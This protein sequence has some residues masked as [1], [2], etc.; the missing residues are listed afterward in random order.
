[1]TDRKAKLSARCEARAT[2]HI[3]VLRSFAGGQENNC[4]ALVHTLAQVQCRHGQHT[5]THAIEQ[6][7]TMLTRTSTRN[8]CHD[9]CFADGRPDTVELH[10]CN[11]KGFGRARR[12]KTTR[13]LWRLPLS[14]RGR[15]SLNA[16]WRLLKKNRL[17]LERVHQMHRQPNQNQMSQRRVLEK[18]H[19]QL[20]ARPV[21]Q[22]RL[23]T[24]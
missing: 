8:I 6:W 15:R 14:F 21:L 13:G 18:H 5:H 10:P 20:L 17:K 11:S 22:P 24:N 23:G 12:S 2:C 3:N 1:M 9:A 16:S 7:K 19:L 4:S